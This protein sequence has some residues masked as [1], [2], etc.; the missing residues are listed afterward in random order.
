MGEENIKQEIRLINIE[1]INRLKWNAEE[2]AQKNSA[3][4]NY[5]EHFLILA[6]TITGCMSISAFASLVAM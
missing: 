5:T 6:Y 1:E 2:E 4:L 3:I